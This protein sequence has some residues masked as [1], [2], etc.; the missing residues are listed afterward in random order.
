MFNAK[1]VKNELVEWIKDYFKN[2][3]SPETKAV[4]GISGG[5]DSSIVAALCVEALG[6][7]RVFG[8]LM[9]DG[10]QQDIDTAYAVCN[11]LGIERTEVNIGSMVYQVYM[12]LLHAN[13]MVFIP[14]EDNEYKKPNP[15]IFNNTPARI[16]MTVLYAVSGSIGGRVANTSNLSEDW[17]GFATKYGDSAGDFSPLANLTVTEIKAIGRELGLPTQFV[18][19]VPEDGLCGTT[20]EENFGFTYD[21]LDKYIRYGVEPEADIKARI[22]KMHQMNLHKVNPIPAYKPNR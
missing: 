20:D 16:R 11:H 9:P 10:E 8:V 18:D 22:D 14:D 17:V 3:A 2:N 4:I 19:K 6:K 12:S 1:L 13:I 21:I 7:E 5:K 15:V